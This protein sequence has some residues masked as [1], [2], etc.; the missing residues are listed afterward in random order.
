MRVTKAEALGRY[1]LSQR[2]PGQ[3]IR[4][5]NKLPLRSAG[6][7]DFRM[8][9]AAAGRREGAMTGRQNGGNIDQDSQIA[10]ALS[11]IG[12][13]LTE[14]EVAELKQREDCDCKDG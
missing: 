9:V 2:L 1:R 11:R 6:S 7:I 4:A 8:R 12:Q 5:E 10:E 13:P 3:A 14:M